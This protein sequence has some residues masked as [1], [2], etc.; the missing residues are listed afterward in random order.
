ERLLVRH[1]YSLRTSWEQAATRIREAELLDESEALELLSNR[2]LS[3]VLALTEPLAP[4]EFAE[5]LLE[6]GKGSGSRLGLARAAL[7]RRYL[8][9]SLR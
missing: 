6:L 1:P 9:L 5:A 3:G 2:R 8:P 4:T 7:L